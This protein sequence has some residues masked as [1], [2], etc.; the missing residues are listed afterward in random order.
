MF[1]S[2]CFADSIALTP[3]SPLNVVQDVNQSFTFGW[4]FTVTSPVTVTALGY[5]DPNDKLKSNHDVGI[6]SSGGSLLLSTTITAG[7]YT[8][9]DGFAFLTVPSIT[10]ADGTYVI[11]GDSFDSK[12][13]F[14]F[15]AS[16]LSPIPQIT[17]GETG[18]FTFGT[19]FA[20]PTTNFASA[21]Y[22]GPDF[23][24]ES[25]ATVPE[26]S[27]SSMLICVVLSFAAAAFGFR[28]SPLNA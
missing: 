19:T 28:R 1:S 23:E 7:K 18:L 3:V 17:L 26:S 27:S 13:P 16:S 22:M 12:D 4:Q 21:T 15:S 9:V 8:T 10:L 6:F 25:S 20:L 11:G 14:I 24:V 5:Y 2:L